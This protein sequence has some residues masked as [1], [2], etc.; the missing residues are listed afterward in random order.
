MWCHRLHNAVGSASF[1]QL[2]VGAVSLRASAICKFLNEAVCQFIKEI[3]TR[4]LNGFTVFIVWMHNCAYHTFVYNLPQQCDQY[5][6][7]SKWN[8][9]SVYKEFHFQSS[10]VKQM[11]LILLTAGSF[12]NPQRNVFA[13]SCFFSKKENFIPIHS[14]RN[15]YQEMCNIKRD[16]SSFRWLSQMVHTTL[17]HL[18]LG[19]TG[20]NEKLNMIY[21]HAMQIFSTWG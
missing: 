4:C 19:K 11:S 20:A 18:L 1:S 16:T 5:L 3:C 6:T 17:L 15:D 8:N 21:L 12:T 14:S 10:R 9:G 7:G 2:N 13:L